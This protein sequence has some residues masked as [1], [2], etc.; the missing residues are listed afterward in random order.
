LVERSS[1]GSFKLDGGNMRKTILAALAGL[2]VF[3]GAALAQGNDAAIY[4]PGSDIQATTKSQAFRIVDVGNAYV[5]VAVVHRPKGGDR[6]PL[7]HSKV[8]EVYIITAGTA[9]LSTGGELTD[10]TLWPKDNKDNG[11]G[12]G[13]GFAGKVAK[14]HDVR[15]IKAGDVIIIPRG[16]S[17]WLSDVNEPLTYLVV[18]IDPEKSTVL[19]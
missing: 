3:S 14:A 1:R 2:L 9:T 19:K 5:G 16:M 17:H 8:T 11:E 7:V 18:R 13:P 6:G 12:I 4:V 10:M 15:P